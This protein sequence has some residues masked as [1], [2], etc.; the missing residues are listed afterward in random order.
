MRE[1]IHRP[2][3]SGEAGRQQHDPSRK[4]EADY[5]PEN[6]LT[7]T[8]ET[9][10]PTSGSPG[11]SFGDYP[12]FAGQPVPDPLRGKFE[13]ST[14]CSVEP[15]RVHTGIYSQR[16]ADALDSRAFT[17]G[18]D[19]HFG[20]NEF[21]PGTE[22]GDHL[23]AHEL[24]HT[25]QQRMTPPT[26][27]MQLET[28]VQEEPAELEADDVADA[29]L[30]DEER[31][32]VPEITE[33]PRMA[34]LRKP[35]KKGK[36]KATTPTTPKPKP[37]TIRLFKVPFSVTVDATGNLTFTKTGKSDGGWTFTQSG[38]NV[39][40]AERTNDPSA[41]SGVQ[42]QYVHAS[43]TVDPLVER[44]TITVPAGGPATVTPIVAELGNPPTLTIPLIGPKNAARKSVTVN[45]TTVEQL[46][47]S[48]GAMSFTPADGDSIHLELGGDA[49]VFSTIKQDAT[50][51]PAAP[52]PNVQGF[53]RTG[54]FTRYMDRGTPTFGVSSTPVPEA[55]RKKAFDDLTKPAAGARRITTDEAERF[56]TVT[57]IED[58]LAGVQN[59]DR[60]I[61]S[62]GFSQWT[63]ASDLPRMLSR[64]DAA[65]FERYLGRYGLAVGAPVR[66]LDAFVHK[67]VGAHRERLG[68]RNVAEQALFLNSKELVSPK[69]LQTATAKAP[70]LNTLATQANTTAAKITAAKPDL[71]STNP[72]VKAAAVKAM[73]DAKKEAVALHKSLAGLSGVKAI[74]DLASDVNNL[75][76][77]AADGK[78]ACDDL[79]ANCESNEA[80]RGEQW[81]LRFEMLGQSPGGQDAEIA[82]VRQNWTDVSS[83]S[84]HGADFITLLPNLRGQSALLSSYLNNPSGT[85]TGMSVAVD[86]FKKQ[87]VKEATASAAAKPKPSAPAATPA[88]W[89]AFPWP[90]GDSR[91][92]TLWSSN[93]KV[94]DQFEA[95][96]IVEMTKH[97]TD[98]K[99]RRG[100]IKKQ[101]P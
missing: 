69:L 74:P 21:Q 100:I 101:F 62:F 35:K 19:I 28:E 68:V 2:K 82:E 32:E 80:L 12:I 98:P 31:T 52:A 89:N 25:V 46:D 38:P 95:I 72:T 87:K 5:A 56:K 86:E 67:F 9:G 22:E 47:L 64:V 66:Q 81:V 16:A 63:V 41:K 15:V 34:I 37:I 11:F 40:K 24:T 51:P 20:R 84:T 83:K 23:L 3:D 85:K 59:Y 27:Q 99:R 78:A 10:G 7:K 61:L 93:P 71:T 45:G 65:T 36:K 17:I 8:L 96:A 76:T 42:P 14:G 50:V 88:D 90:T 91:W 73:K 13:R 18:N 29:V 6:A 33:R 58:D 30:D 60:G 1:L 43:G 54:Y 94:I 26:P 70:V 49:W 4:M 53:F 55:D 92:G 57:I 48:A 77:V 44:C 79:V 75:A 39:A 97:T